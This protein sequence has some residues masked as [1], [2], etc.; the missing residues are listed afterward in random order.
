MDLNIRQAKVEDKPKIIELLKETN[1]HDYIFHVLDEWLLDDKGK[2]LVVHYD[3]KIIAISHFFLKN[4]ES[5]WLEGARVHPNYRNLGI[6]TKMNLFILETLR[7]EGIKKARLVTS[8]K[9]IPSQRH[10]AKTPFKPTSRWLHLRV[11]KLEPK[12]IQASAEYDLVLNF[13][14]NSKFFEE[15]GRIYHAGYAWFDFNQDWLFERI[16]NKE[17]YFEDPNLVIVDKSFR[18]NN[19]TISYLECPKDVL[20]D[21]L[22]I[23]CFLAKNKEDFI[24]MIPSRDEYKEILLDKGI[25]FDELI[26]YEAS[27]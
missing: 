14:L 5:A 15:I 24:L 17:V 3:D 6:A 12:E 21:M 1:P 18:R 20:I 11:D 8:S 26:V 7:K 19:Y 10:L 2:L 25:N 23:A 16:M 27:L 22:K 13:L 4:K 9:N